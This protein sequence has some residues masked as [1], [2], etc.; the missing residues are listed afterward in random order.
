MASSG[1]PC[2]YIKGESLRE[3]LRREG[4]LHVADA[5]RITRE[6]A[7]ALAYAH[8]AGVVHRDVKPENILLTEDGS[9]ML[10]DLGIALRLGS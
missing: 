10:A 3:R 5:L 6:C 2:P 4:R 7:E 1:I 9:P 8:H